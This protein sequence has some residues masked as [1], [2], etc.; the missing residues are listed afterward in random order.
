MILMLSHEISHCMHI[1]VKFYRKVYFL[2]LEILHT[3]I[4]IEKYFR[5]FELSQLDLE[6]KQLLSLIG[7]YEQ[8]QMILQRL[9]LIDTI[10]NGEIT[11]DLA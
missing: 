1:G 10:F 9:D 6:V 4:Q 2:R 11:I 5:E 8:R 3:Q 7:T